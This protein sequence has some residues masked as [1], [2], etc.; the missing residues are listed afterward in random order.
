MKII[1]LILFLH[2]THPTSL[3]AQ[4]KSI[5]PISR[6]DSLLTEFIINY[7]YKKYLGKTIGEFLSENTFKNFK[8]KRYYEPKMATV[9][10]VRLTYTEDILVIPIIKKFKNIKSYNKNRNWDFADIMKE[11]I[12]EFRII[13]INDEFWVS[14]DVKNFL[15]KRNKKIILGIFRHKKKSEGKTVRYSTI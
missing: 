15:T 5:S 6:N 2:F 7:N 13:Y 9:K 1:C 4:V 8:G 10:G 3:S 14:P 11:Q 12:Y